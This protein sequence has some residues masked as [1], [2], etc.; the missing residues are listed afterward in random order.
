MPY[1]AR[2][3]YL[4]ALSSCTIFLP[5]PTAL[6]EATGAQNQS[7][8]VTFKLEEQSLILVPVTVNGSGPYDFLLDTGCT[9]TIVDRKLA[10]ELALPQ[11]RGA[12]VVGVFAA[13]KMTAV[14]VNALSVGGVSV[15]EGDVLVADR[16]AT[17]TDKV[18]GVLG[19]DFLHN[20]DL[21][22]DYRHRVIRIGPAHGSL[23]EALAG[24]HLPLQT[25]STFHGKPTH[26]RVIVSGSIQEEEEVT[27]SLLLDSGAGQLTL[28]KENLC[29][30]KSHS[31]S[32]WTGNFGRWSSIR[33]KV[34]ELSALSLGQTSISDLNAIEVPRR[35]DVDSDGLLPTS[36][37]QSVFIC[38]SEKFVILNPTLR[39][40]SSGSQEWR[41]TR[42]T[43]P[44]PSYTCKLF[45]NGQ[46]SPFADARFRAS[47]AISEFFG[48]ASCIDPA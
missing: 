26:N 32:I 19:E 36:L 22:I 10:G 8:T 21:L 13:S 18:R 31:K 27:L 46:E 20:F 39:I 9:K 40:A 17:I 24:E 6:P 15:V 42:Q 3:Y 5:L 30:T 33:A 4:L 12:N 41:R 28:F 7:A 48:I 29:P 1:L 25:N 35:A 44:A 43:R 11:A 23:A 37:F 16:A 38:H 2:L 34:C 14:H 47:C 45:A